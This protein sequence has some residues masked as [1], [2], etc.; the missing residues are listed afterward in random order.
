MPIKDSGNG[1]FHLIETET[2]QNNE[3][4]EMNT[5]ILLDINSRK[6]EIPSNHISCIYKDTY[7]D[8]EAVHDVEIVQKI[9]DDINNA[10]IVRLLVNYQEL[11][12]MEEPRDYE[13]YPLLL[14]MRSGD[15]FVHIGM[16][17]HDEVNYYVQL[18]M[19]LPSDGIKYMGNIDTDLTDD[20]SRYINCSVNSKELYDDVVALWGERIVPDDLQ[21]SSD[22]E[23][24][25]NS[26]SALASGQDILQAITFNPNDVTKLIQSLSADALPIYDGHSFGITLVFKTLEKGDISLYY[27][28]DG[29]AMFQLDGVSYMLD[30]DSD[31]ARLV[32]KYI[33]KLEEKISEINELKL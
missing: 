30:S 25:Y 32:K 3:P 1:E 10:E 4:Q 33:Q 26:S 9:C 15:E 12:K 19:V 17:A 6:I 24:L 20:G 11:V 13:Q 27:A 16:L 29:C 21:F 5:S 31:S 22:I 14:E 28:E 18:D 2:R 23:I 8:K 7:L